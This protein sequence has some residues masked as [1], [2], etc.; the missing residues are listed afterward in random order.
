MTKYHINKKGIPAP[1]KATKGNCPLGGDESHFSS[2][3]EAQAAV[4]SQN[5]SDYG[6]LPQ[7]ESNEETTKSKPN[8]KDFNEVFPDSWRD[9]GYLA[10]GPIKEDFEENVSEAHEKVYS[11]LPDKFHEE[12]KDVRQWR[13]VKE[14]NVEAHMRE[15]VVSAGREEAVDS[16]SGYN[17]MVNTIKSHYGEN[18]S[19]YI[20]EEN[21]VI[22]PETE[23]KL[24]KF[25]AQKA[26]DESYVNINGKN[27]Y[28]STEKELNRDWAK[29][30]LNENTKIEKDG[31]KAELIGEDLYVTLPNGDKKKGF[32]NED[33]FGSKSQSSYLALNRASKVINFDELKNN[34]L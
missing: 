15:H 21:N 20:D 1:C 7:V 32:L 3:E 22:K 11:S 25:A 16:D 29:E 2:Q 6:I 8:E 23:E 28:V 31:Y 10:T 34:N 13:L 19:K 24:A 5:A 12:V 4:D 33:G 17:D 14:D 30:Y 9:S 27:V 26:K 18:S